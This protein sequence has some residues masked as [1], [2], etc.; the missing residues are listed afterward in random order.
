MSWSSR[1]RTALRRGLRARWFSARR[2]RYVRA[3]QFEMFE[4]R[5]LLAVDWRNPADALDVNHDRAIA[6][7]DALLVITEL[8]EV[9]SHALADDKPATALF[10]DTSGDQLVAPRD[11]LLV[12]NAL[13]EDIS[14]PRVL[15]ESPRLVTEQPVTITVGQDY[16]SRIYRAK[17]TANFDTTDQQTALDL[18]DIEATAGSRESRLWPQGRTRLH[19]IPPFQLDRRRT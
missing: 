18:F 1:S 17:I 16:G 2:Q 13:N 7:L 5:C 10:L 4:E 9:G 14:G 8:N 15:R 19:A 11:A 3:L 6:P 12:I